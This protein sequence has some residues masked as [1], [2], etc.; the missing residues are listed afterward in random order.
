MKGSL[1]TILGIAAAL[2]IMLMGIFVPKALL[3]AEESRYLAMEWGQYAAVTP[4]TDPGPTPT[5][6]PGKGHELDVGWLYMAESML[7]DE[8]AL[9]VREPLS[10]E[11]SMEQAARTVANEL[12]LLSALGALPGVSIA[13]LHFKSGELRGYTDLPPYYD[14][15]GEGGTSPGI[16]FGIWTIKFLGADGRTVEAECDSQS[17]L[18]Y[19]VRFLSAEELTD[20]DCITA[21]IGYAK[22]LGFTLSESIQFNLSFE[23]AYAA[24]I[25]GVTLSIDPRPQMTTLRLLQPSEYEATPLPTSTPTPVPTESPSS[26]IIGGALYSPAP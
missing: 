1:T 2:A 3:K 10:F 5:P 19:S 6:L 22:F 23:G 14:F 9:F 17:G 8:G 24:E 21:L 4:R 18:V 12:E 13:G 7:N 16:P 15:M 20:A 11:M 25:C 26:V